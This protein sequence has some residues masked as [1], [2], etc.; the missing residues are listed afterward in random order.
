MSSLRNIRHSSR[1]WRSERISFKK[2]I[3]QR[4][5]LSLR[6]RS[7]IHTHEQEI[8]LLRQD[9]EDYQ[10]LKTGKSGNQRDDYRKRSEQQEK[11][12]KPQQ[13]RDKSQDR[14]HEPEIRC[15]LNA[16]PHTLKDKIQF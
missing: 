12:R 1:R 14:G 7:E 11:E 13:K 16:Q 15:P 8:E 6:Q 10:N 9:I 3:Q 2:H 4:Q 5:Q